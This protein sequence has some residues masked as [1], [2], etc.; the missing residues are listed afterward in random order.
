MP[1]YTYIIVYKG[2]THVAQARHSNFTGFVSSWPTD[3]PPNAL[4]S[5]GLKLRGELAKKAYQGHFA[6][7]PN[8]KN[9]W[10]SSR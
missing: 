1:L 7:V 8:R 5:L 4:P 2:E 6:E 3:L 9:V 10:R